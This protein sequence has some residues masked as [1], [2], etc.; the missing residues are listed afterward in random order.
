MN[1][2]TY[3]SWNH[4]CFGVVSF[5]SP[6]PPPLAALPG[7]MQAFAGKP[8]QSCTAVCAEA[9]RTCTARDPSLR[10]ALLLQR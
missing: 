8:G 1:E 2:N 10:V 6:V 5:P 7:T 9:K 4:H 3:L